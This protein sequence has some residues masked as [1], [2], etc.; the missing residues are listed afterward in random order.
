MWRIQVLRGYEPFNII[1]VKGTGIIYKQL[2]TMKKLQNILAAALILAMAA[3]TAPTKEK[4]EKAT[5]E[6]VFFAASKKL[7]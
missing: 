1:I 6:G 4:A 2:Y 5:S 7:L 3:C